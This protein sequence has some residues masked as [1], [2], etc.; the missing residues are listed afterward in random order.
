MDTANK[1]PKTPAP[2]LLESEIHGDVPTPLPP[3]EGGVQLEGV[4]FD[5]PEGAE[6]PPGMP[7]GDQSVATNE[8]TAQKSTVTVDAPTGVDFTGGMGQD[9]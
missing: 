3:G 2:N 4:A 8:D 5:L 6:P 9:T 7:T 1:D